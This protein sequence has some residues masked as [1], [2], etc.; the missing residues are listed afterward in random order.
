[1]TIGI[2]VAL[3]TVADFVT[4]SFD[5]RDAVGVEVAYDHF[6]AIR[7]QGKADGSTADVKQSEY[8][9]I[10]SLRIF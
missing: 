1:M 7:F 4:A 9:I 3:L 8:T 10:P 2:V 5:D 6:S